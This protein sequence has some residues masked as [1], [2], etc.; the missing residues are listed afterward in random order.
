MPEIRPGSELDVIGHHKMFLL[1]R[2]DDHVI[3]APDG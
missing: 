3:V 2:S 1:Q